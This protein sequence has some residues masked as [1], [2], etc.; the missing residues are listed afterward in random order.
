MVDIIVIVDA[1]EDE[2]PQIEALLN[3]WA[4]YAGLI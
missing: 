1:M 2:D 3:N 4:E